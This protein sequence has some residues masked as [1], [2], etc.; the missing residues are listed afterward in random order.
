MRSAGMQFLFKQQLA[1][2]PWISH[3]SFCRST[4]STM[5]PH[6][7]GV[8]TGNSAKSKSKRLLARGPEIGDQT[9]TIRHQLWRFQVCSAATSWFS[10]PWSQN[11]SGIP[12]A[13]RGYTKQKTI[14]SNNQNSYLVC[15]GHWLR[16]GMFDYCRR[17]LAKQTPRQHDLL[18]VHW[19]FTAWQTLYLTYS[20]VFWRI[21]CKSCDLGSSANSVLALFASFITLSIFT[22]F[23]RFA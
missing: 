5:P 21:Y 17:N 10:Y 7:I 19:L 1:S 6:T 22:N 18:V 4:C 12:C 11:Y 20:D 13:L 14:D 23:S 2:S 16:S 15:W 9:S 3:L 8:A